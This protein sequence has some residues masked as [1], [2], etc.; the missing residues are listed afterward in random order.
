M[1]HEA[2]GRALAASLGTGKGTCDLF[3][4][5]QTDAIF[6]IGVN[7]ATNAPRM[8]TALGDGVNERDMKIVHINPLIEVAATDAITPH[9]IMAMLTLKTTK[10]SSLNLQPRVGGD[11]C[12]YP[13][14]RQ[15]FVRAVY[16]GQK[17][18]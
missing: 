13:R 7:V 2:S 10:T 1:C 15:I 3:D 17:L 9:E 8:L 5:Q 4:V 18:Q 11:F 16:N 6:V 14:H 12:N